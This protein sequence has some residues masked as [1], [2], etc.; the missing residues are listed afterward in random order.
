MASLRDWLAANRGAIRS[1][2]ALDLTSVAVLSALRTVLRLKVR[3]CQT[4]VWNVVFP[5]FV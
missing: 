2:A 4:A 3:G 1:Q 5:V